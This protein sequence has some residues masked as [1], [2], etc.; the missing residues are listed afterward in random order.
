MNKTVRNIILRLT[1][2]TGLTVFIVLA[3]L[4]KIKR[5]SIAVS[6]V[7][8]T[9]DGQ[10]ENLFVTKEQ[11]ETIIDTKFQVQNSVL[12]GKELERIEKTLAKI[13]HVLHANAYTDNIGNLNIKIDQ[14]KPVLR[15][16]NL[17][18]DSYYIDERGIKFPVTTHFTSKVPVVTGNIT[19]ACNTNEKVRSDAL[20]DVFK[21]AQTISR[22]TLWKELVAQYHV[23]D[24][25]QTELI[26]RIGSSVILFGNYKDSEEK[27]KRMDIFYFEVL[28]KVGWD[29][30]RVINIMYKDQVVCLK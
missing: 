18:G 7:N 11:I 6:K 17:L 24:H 26:P 12:S 30:Y 22:N 14:R 21:I 20:T 16:Y 28:K 4:A 8:I 13:P 29:Q 10:Q 1:M 15:V 3:V 5:E 23:N 27:L 25:N 19:E 2:L 9:I